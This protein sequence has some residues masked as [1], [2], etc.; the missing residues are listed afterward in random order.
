MTIISGE[1]WERINHRALETALARVREALERYLAR[2]NHVSS[3]AS[4]RPSFLESDSADERS[5]LDTLCATFRLSPFERDLLALCAGVELD[6]GIATLCAEAQGD[7]LDVLRG[8]NLAAKLQRCAPKR[9]AIHS[10]CRRLSAW[11]SPR[12][13]A[14]TGARWRPMRRY[15]TGV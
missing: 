2:L 6:A 14:R 10:G 5:A 4:D 7:P 1:T 13:L 3:T 8:R 15:A 9:K 11:R 12:C